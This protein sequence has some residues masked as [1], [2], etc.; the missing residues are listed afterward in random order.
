MNSNV[1]SNEWLLILL[2]PL[3]IITIRS[4]AKNWKSLWDNDLTAND[5]KLLMQAT[6]ILLMPL[7]VLVHEFGH[8]AAVK[9][10]GGEVVGFYYALMVG[11]VL[12]TQLP[13]PEQNVLVALAGT[14]ADVVLGLIALVAAYFSKSPPVVAVCVYFALWCIGGNTISYALLSAVNAYGDWRNI[15]LSPARQLVTAIG[16]AHATVV[17]LF[18][19]GIFA[20]TPKVWFTSKTRPVWFKQFTQL[21]ERIKSEPT[22]VNYLNLAWSYYLVGIEDGAKQS[23]KM[24]EKL[25]P[26]LLDRWLLKGYIQ[27]SKGKLDSA[28][29]CFEEVAESQQA[30]QTLRCRGHMAIGHCMMEQAHQHEANNKS[31]G[32][33]IWD[34]AI[35]AYTQASL[36]DQSL[37]DPRFYLATALNKAGMHKEAEKQLLTARE[38]TWL[39]PTLSS[40]V[41][42]ELAITRKRA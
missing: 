8:M 21:K 26:S 30:S 11:E 28:I 38:L 41:A 1:R 9:F 23:L 6:F 18:F 42:N 14:I 37:A 7:A 40:L 17:A 12:H 34:D 3:M 22:A 19:W 31:P 32:A 15:Y 13:S 16:I 20:I 36:T 35:Q 25:D 10:F 29:E 33:E 39:D 4:V 24:V 27:Q 5:R 2:I